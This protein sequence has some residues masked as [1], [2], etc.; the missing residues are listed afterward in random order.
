M[1]QNDDP[2]EHT[3]NVEG[4]DTDVTVPASGEAQFS[5][6]TKPGDYALT[7]DFH[8]NMHGNLTVAK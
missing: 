5:A 6:P 4:T 3:V 8:S 2:S 7:C 1:V